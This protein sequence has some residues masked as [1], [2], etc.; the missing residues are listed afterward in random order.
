LA[1]ACHDGKCSLP[2]NVSVPSRPAWRRRSDCPFRQKF[3][4]R[5]FGV[6]G[7]RFRDASTDALNA[8]RVRTLSSLR[9]R[10][11]LC[12][13]STT[14]T[15]G[16]ERVAVRKT[17]KFGRP[18]R[19]RPVRIRVAIGQREANASAAGRTATVFRVL[20]CLR[21]DV[22][23]RTTHADGRRT[24]PSESF[25]P[26]STPD[27]RPYAFA[28]SRAKA[29]QRDGDPGVLESCRCSQHQSDQT[30]D[31]KIRLWHIAAQSAFR[32]MPI[33]AMRASGPGRPAMCMGRG[34]DAWCPPEQRPAEAPLPSASVPRRLCRVFALVQRA[35]GHT[36]HQPERGRRL[37]S[38]D[39]ST[40]VTGTMGSGHPCWWR[41]KHRP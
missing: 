24:N 15:D 40:P 33:L 22:P 29:V 13:Q 35:G 31:E 1:Q 34:G 25:P 2:R 9:V 16:C 23:A 30:S 18:I 6:C 5:P 41:A 20:D 36:A 26:D 12:A 32:E 28:R 21:A 17:A 3:Y 38:L 7:R 14:T 39:F 27:S 8:L 19:F 4:I 37:G 11:E 10:G